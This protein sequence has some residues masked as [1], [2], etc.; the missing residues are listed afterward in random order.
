MGNQAKSL[1]DVVRGSPPGVEQGGSWRHVGD[2]R[3]AN[4]VTTK[5]THS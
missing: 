3:R 4:S 2:E 1:E 5:A